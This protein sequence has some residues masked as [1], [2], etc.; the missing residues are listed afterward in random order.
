M[1]KTWRNEA[2]VVMT[3][4]TCSIVGFAA[5]SSDEQLGRRRGD[6]LGVHQDPLS[7]APSIP[8]LDFDQNADDPSQI[9][10]TFD[11]G[12]EATSTG[13]VLD[14]LKNAGVKATFFINTKNFIDVSSSSTGRN[15]IERMHSEGHHIGNHTVHHYDLGS[16]STN[17]RSEIDGVYQTMKS[18][19]P[20]ALQRRLFRAPFG[21][22]YFGPQ[23]RLDYVAPIA[24][25]YGVHIG[26]NIDPMD[27]DCPDSAC[28][29]DHVLSDVDAGKNGIV[30]MHATE[31]QTAAA[32]PK[33]ISEL[34]SRG[35]RFVFVEDLVVDKYGKPS[36]QLITCHYDSDCVSGERCGSDGHC[37]TSSGGSTDSGVADSGST[38]SGST[39][40]GSGSGATVVTYCASLT[41]TAGTV[42]NASTACG[43]SGALATQNGTNAR[44][45]PSSTSTKTTAYAQYNLTG[46]PKSLEVDVSYLGDDGTEPLWYWSILDPSTGAWV[47]IGDNS[48]AG[49]WVTTAHAF[50]VA[51]PAKYADASGHVKIRFKTNTS[52]NDAEL[53]RMILKVGY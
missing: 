51:S 6:S 24:A 18:I 35:K 27:Y 47:Q 33:L 31:P 23:S 42:A 9:A 46:V 22:P 45:S 12:P 3:L 16:S 39:D 36:R 1:R 19:V 48:W 32:L 28:V 43:S 5:C 20:G 25:E 38:D 44:W 49:N 37:T 26:W 4:F 13:K 7:L 8:F 21:N 50:T 41:V 52:T 40:S 2:L 15:L 29:L 34:K 14:A 53:D 11:D 10:L 30:L 17:V